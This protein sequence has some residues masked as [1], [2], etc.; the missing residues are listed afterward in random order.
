MRVKAYPAE[1]E[2]VGSEKEW[3]KKN[4]KRQATEKE[5]PW[6]GSAK[7]V[8]QRREGKEDRPRHAAWARREKRKEREWSNAGETRVYTPNTAQ[9]GN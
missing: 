4:R 3:P 8:A 2:A 5:Q 1:L 6:A 7:I 9:S